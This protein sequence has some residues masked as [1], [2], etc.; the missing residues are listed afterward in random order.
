VVV[1]G[2]LEVSFQAEGELQDPLPLRLHG[3]HVGLDALGCR[4]PLQNQGLPAVL[5]GTELD[6]TLLQVAH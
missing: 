5:D 3:G 1:A 6:F 4:V 2:V